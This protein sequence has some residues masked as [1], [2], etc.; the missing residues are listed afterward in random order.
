MADLYSIKDWDEYFENSRSRSMK[1]TLWTPI[2]NRFDGDRIT[3]LICEGG[4][5]VYAAWV[6]V[7]LVAGRCH[8]RGTL[9]TPS[10]KPHTPQSLSRRTGISE[11]AFKKMLQIAVNV[12]LIDADKTMTG[13]CHKNDGEVSPKCLP[14]EDIE[15]MESRED[16]E[17]SVDQSP[18][19]KRTLR[20]TITKSQ[21]IALYRMYPKQVGRD[22]AV[23]AIGKAFKKLV[24]EK[25]RFADGPAILT[26]L[27]NRVTAYAE[28]KEH[29][30]KQY[31][32]HPATWFNEGRYDDNPEE[33]EDRKP[34][35][36]YPPTHS[37]PTDE[38]MRELLAND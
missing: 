10:E 31:I 38:Q 5:A 37:E 13:A 11:K 21:C 25:D 30:D 12:G 23:K 28:A 22:A 19:R 20:L 3:E 18:D 2:P 14:M 7:I 8:P 4:D 24:E 6:A 15:G 26:Y 36:N 32:P 33:W 17:K 16:I 1:K 34:G 29:A 9:I 27:Q 35:E